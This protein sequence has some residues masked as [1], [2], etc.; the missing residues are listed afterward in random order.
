LCLALLTGAS[1]KTELLDAFTE[2]KGASI[3][4]PQVLIQS[5]LMG[6]HDATFTWSNNGSSGSGTLSK[7]QFSLRIEGDLFFPRG[8]LSLIVGPTGCG[9]T[10]LLM[11]LL[12][13]CSKYRKLV[14]QTQYSAGEMHFI[15]TAPDSWFNLPRAGGIAFAAQES[16]VQNETIKVGW[17]KRLFF[18][19]VLI[20]LVRQ[21]NILFGSPFN[22]E[23]YQRVIY[24]CGLTRDL[25]LFEA[26]DQTE[27]GEKGLTLSGGQKARITLARAVYS[28]AEIL[29]LDDIL[30]ALE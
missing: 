19:V 28:K 21:D 9:K 16:W 15:P 25:K 22:E 14:T 2:P 8:Q 1:N 4:D 18:G 29:L 30:A 11:A 3:I 17:F 13:R 12:G 7:R 23:R 6:F 10:S 5:D 27:V 20:N 26:G 24:Q